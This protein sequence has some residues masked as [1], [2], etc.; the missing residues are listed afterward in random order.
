MGHSRRVRAC[1]IMSMVIDID[2]DVFDKLSFL[3]T[4]CWVGFTFRNKQICE[5]CFIFILDRGERGRKWEGIHERLKTLGE[6]HGT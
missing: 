4:S 2:G 5:L 6:G 1:S 3:L